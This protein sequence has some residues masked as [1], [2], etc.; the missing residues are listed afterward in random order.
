MEARRRH[1]D[2]KVGPPADGH[3]EAAAQEEFDQQGTQKG[4]RGEGPEHP[5]E[6]IKS[7]HTI[8]LMFHGYQERTPW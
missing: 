1:G 8:E 4:R 3:G 5:D 7:K 6:A 2:G